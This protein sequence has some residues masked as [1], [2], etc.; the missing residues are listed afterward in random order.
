M[1]TAIAWVVAVCAF[2]ALFIALQ[3]GPS[4]ASAVG[5]FSASAFF[6]SGLWLAFR[7]DRK[8]RGR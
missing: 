3:I 4:C 2:V 7:Y 8:D 6:A 5:P 1:I